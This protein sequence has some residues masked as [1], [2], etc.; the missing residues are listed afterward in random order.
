MKRGIIVTILGVFVLAAVASA[1][2]GQGQRRGQRRGQQDQDQPGQGQQDRIR[3]QQDKPQTFPGDRP[4]RLDTER[5]PR[6]PDSRPLQ[7]RLNR[8]RGS[9][10]VPSAQN[11]Q[12]RF[13]NPPAPDQRGL[14]N[15]IRPFQG[16]G[17]RFGG[18]RG[19]QAGPG[20][21]GRQDGFGRFYQR[22]Q[23]QN[24][25]RV[26]QRPAGPGLRGR[27]L[28]FQNRAGQGRGPWQNLRRGF[29]RRQNRP[30]QA[31]F[32]QEP[33]SRRDQIHRPGLGPNG[34]FN[35]APQRPEGNRR[36]FLG[37]WGFGPQR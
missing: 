33:L 20:S 2:Q 6:D 15:Q 28:G 5:P 3:L 18:L 34:P 27:Q 9:R 14:Q 4:Q 16:R 1:Q 11:R 17:Q 25:D 19:P 13:F 21:K 32:G 7:R 10:N 26:M 36:S 29:R 23:R 30:G 37:P 24:P 35:L 12:G 8:E 22:F 31:L